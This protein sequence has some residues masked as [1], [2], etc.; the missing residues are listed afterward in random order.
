MRVGGGVGEGGWGGVSPLG[1]DHI[2]ANVKIL[3]QFSHL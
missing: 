1:P 2:E 3:V